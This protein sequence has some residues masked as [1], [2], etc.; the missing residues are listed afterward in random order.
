[1]SG[2]INELEGF[3]NSGSEFAVNHCEYRGKDGE[4]NARPGDL[5][6]IAE[7]CFFCD[8]TPETEGEIELC[9]VDYPEECPYIL[10]GKTSETQKETTM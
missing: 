5:V 4:C 3:C 10:Y 1:M 6:E 7:D 8:G 2:C 9:P